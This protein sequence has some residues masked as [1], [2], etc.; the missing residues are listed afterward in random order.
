[1]AVHLAIKIKTECQLKVHLHTV[2]RLAN[3]W[4]LATSDRLAADL[5]M[6]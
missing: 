6:E 1:M 3:R 4:L 5:L 2:H